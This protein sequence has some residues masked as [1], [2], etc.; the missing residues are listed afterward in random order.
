MYKTFAYIFFYSWLI[1]INNILMIIIF[2]NNKTILS[3]CA[4]NMFKPIKYVNNHSIIYLPVVLFSDDRKLRKS[5][6]VSSHI[7]AMLPRRIPFNQIAFAT[8]IGIGGGFYIYK[9]MFHH[10][11]TTSPSVEANVPPDTRNTGAVKTDSPELGVK[12]PEAAQDVTDV[13]K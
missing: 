2:I 13:C 5:S 7:S 4:I 9:P 1:C 6:S 8:V 3:L 11:G 12:R 10:R